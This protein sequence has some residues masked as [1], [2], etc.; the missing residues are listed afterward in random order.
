MFGSRCGAIP[1]EG[2]CGGWVGYLA[3]HGIDADVSD[4]PHRPT[5]RAALGIPNE[6]ASCHTAL[7]DGYVLEGHIPVGALERL[8]TDRPD[9]IGL[10]LAWMPADSPGM[11][12]DEGTWESQPVQSIATDGSLATYEY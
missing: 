7:V 10:G 5:R 9:L 4:D 11:G 2:C 6:A 8:L 12:G 1:V 3:E